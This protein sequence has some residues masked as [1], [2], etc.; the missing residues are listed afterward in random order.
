MDVYTAALPTSEHLDH[1]VDQPV[2]FGVDTI[3]GHTP[4]RVPTKSAL[5]LFRALDDHLDRRAD[6]PIGA[7]ADRH[8]E[9]V[10]AAVVVKLGGFGIRSRRSQPA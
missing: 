7:R 3:V 4:A 1:A 9:S 8:S 5:A 10:D 2:V 6:L